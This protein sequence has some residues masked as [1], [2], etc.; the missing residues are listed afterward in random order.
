MALLLALVK[1]YCFTMHDTY[2]DMHE[3]GLINEGTL[4][5]LLNDLKILYEEAERLHQDLGPVAPAT[6][7]YGNAPL[8]A[9]QN[10]ALDDD[11]EDDEDDAEFTHAEDEA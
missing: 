10:A 5:K 1:D 7:V 6:P 8:T 9:A 3:N 4:V 11:E 2:Q